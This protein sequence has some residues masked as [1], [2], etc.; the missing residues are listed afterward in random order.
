MSVDHYENFP[1]A[2]VLLPRRLVPAVEAIYAFARSA[3]DL[4]DE[5]DA[6][7][8]QRLAALAAYEQALDGIAAGARSGLDPMF[9][10]LA[11]VIAQYDLPLQPFRDLLSA[12]KQDV[13]VTRYSTYEALLDYCARSANPVGLL[14]LSLYGQADADNVRD[15]D[16]ICSALQIINFLQDVAID[17]H[18][19]RIYL[20]M[21]DLARF[22]VSPAALDHP[23]GTAKWR[24]LMKFE[25]ARAR[26]L[27]L[28]GA[29][30]AL[31]LRGRIGLELRMVVQGGL[32]ILESIEEVDYDVF[33]RRPKLTRKDWLKMIWR[34]LRMKARMKRLMKSPPAAA[35]PLE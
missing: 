31:R 33:R 20:P 7:P 13:T 12:F 19:E 21:E 23:G 16:A 9:T 27:M 5:G 29:P 25:V 6:T 28:S 22:A 26:A 32:R 17:L 2:S 24:N 18:K 14:M 30:L 4:A 15:S 10:R 11:G 3:D 34:G 1:V 35:L 8:E